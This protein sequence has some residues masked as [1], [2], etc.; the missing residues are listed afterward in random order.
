MSDQNPTFSLYRYNPRRRA[1]GV[2]AAEVE[3][4]WPDGRRD[5]LWM[6]ERNIRDNLKEFGESA[7][8][9]EALEAYRQNDKIK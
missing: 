9:R 3:V 6:S 5:L 4:K 8:L 1:R 2:E 7:G